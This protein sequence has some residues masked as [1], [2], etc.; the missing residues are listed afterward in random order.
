MNNSDALILIIE[1][2]ISAAR[3]AEYTLQHAGYDVAVAHDGY[4]GLSKALNCHPALI[5]LDIM[6]PGIDGF[7]VCQR[8]RERPDMNAIPILV[9]SAKSHEEDI[10]FGKEMGASEYLVKPVD[11]SSML[12]AIDRLLGDSSCNLSGSSNI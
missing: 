5:I 11:P 9:I 8:L 12:E 10:R 7:E 2:D 6:L 1:D 3:L 4:E